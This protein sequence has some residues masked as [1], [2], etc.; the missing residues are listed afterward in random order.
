MP[1]KNISGAFYTFIAWMPFLAVIVGVVWVLAVGVLHLEMDS[2]GTE[3]F[4]KN[5]ETTNRPASLPSS[6]QE[7][8]LNAELNN[9]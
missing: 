3:F 8:Q 9:Y 5:S 6:P 4:V 2:Y 1:A 7:L